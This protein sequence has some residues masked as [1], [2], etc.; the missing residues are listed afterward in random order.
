MLRAS[1]ERTTGLMGLPC[2]CNV[3]LVCLPGVM[4]RRREK[5]SW[6]ERDDKWERGCAPEKRRLSR[7]RRGT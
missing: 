7:S 3:L 6:D 5:V 1:A 4:D 2:M